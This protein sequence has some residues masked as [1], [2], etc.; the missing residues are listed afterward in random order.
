[1]L[2]KRSPGQAPNSSDAKEWRLIDRLVWLCIPIG[3][4][5]FLIILLLFGVSWW[6][7][8]GIAF[9]IVCPVAAFSM[10][11]AERRLP[12]SNRRKR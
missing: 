7:A 1:M 11:V 6:S 10:L 3:F 4:V 8:L 9:L 2:P 5:A 12:G